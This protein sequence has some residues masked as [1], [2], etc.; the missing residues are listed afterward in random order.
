MA[1]EQKMTT[2]LSIWTN[3]VTDMVVSDFAQNGVAFSDYAKE[4][5]MNAMSS[6]Y[7]LVK[8][9]NVAMNDID[10]SN[11]REIV[12]QCASLKLN[13]NGFPRECYFQLRKKKVGDKY[14]QTVELGVEGAGAE[15]MLRNFGINVDTVYD[16]WLVKEGDDFTYPK[17]KGLT[18]TDP[19]WEQKGLSQKTIRV[20]LPIKL[21]DGTVTYLI[22][23][24]ES[25]KT[26][27]FAHVR[28]NLMNETFG[29]C[30]SRYKATDKQKKDIDAK[31]EVIYEALRKCETVEDMLA[32][33]EAKPFISGAWIDTS[34]SMIIR[35]MQ[36]N[37][38]KK[39]PKN[40]DNMAKQSFLEMDETY[41]ATQEEIAE[42]ANTIPF[43]E[44]ENVVESTATVIE[45]ADA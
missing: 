12:G 4:C 30:E 14:V 5:A 28:N 29:I 2:N 16:W 36:N 40:F 15:S 41:K 13:A 17:R 37:A 42:E 26:N 20:V 10:S 1:D 45:D 35:K 22:S 18:M 25:V 33:A 3:S 39:Y 44:D 38:V 21:K 23:E 6:I 9:S 19:E 32:C 43:E 24:R 34:E 7:Q 11:L 27:L 31:K 8:S